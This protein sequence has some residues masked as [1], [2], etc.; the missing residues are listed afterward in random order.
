MDKKV[1]KSHKKRVRFM[2]GLWSKEMYN[3][4]MRSN[5]LQSKI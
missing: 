1:L 2:R 3:N 4:G 5:Q